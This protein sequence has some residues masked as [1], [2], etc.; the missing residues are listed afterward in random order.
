LVPFSA[1]ATVAGL[2]D[3]D[4][5]EWRLEL[6]ATGPRTVTVPKAAARLEWFGGH[7]EGCNYLGHRLRA[8]PCALL[9]TGAVHASG[10]GV[11]DV[12]STTR[13]D[14]SLGV[15]A[16]AAVVSG[17]FFGEI[18]AFLLVPF[19]RDR[20]YVDPRVTVFQSSTVGAQFGADVGLL[21]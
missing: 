5:V 20:F 15:G 9:E 4:S 11:K 8:G 7:L 18:G 3:F 12:Q 14:A 2:F 16:R 17:H 13:F 21:F 6:S 1:A 19:R 10:V